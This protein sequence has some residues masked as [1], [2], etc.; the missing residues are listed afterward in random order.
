MTAARGQFRLQATIANHQFFVG[1]KVDRR[2]I[3]NK[4]H[5]HIIVRSEMSQPAL[6]LFIQGGKIT[7][8]H[9]QM[10]VMGHTH[11]L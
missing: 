4:H 5:D 8:N 11:N 3:V 7:K 10:V 2:R 1:F 6:S 9:H